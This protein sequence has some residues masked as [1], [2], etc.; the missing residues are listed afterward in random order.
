M[1]YRQ[2]LVIGIPLHGISTYAKII[3]NVNTCMSEFASFPSNNVS[4]IASFVV[5]F[6]LLHIISAFSY[7][8][9]VKGALETLWNV[10]QGQNQ[11]PV[12]P[13]KSTKTKI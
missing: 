7:Y 13:P 1:E 5:I 6:T 4:I 12:E 10:H 8:T 9:I 3:S 11:H 2:Y